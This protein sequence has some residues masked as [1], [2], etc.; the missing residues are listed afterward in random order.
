M[1]R[2]LRCS[3]LFEQVIV[4]RVIL[5]LTIGF[6]GAC[7][8]GAYA[9][10]YSGLLLCCLLSMVAG[11]VFLL[12]RSK[13]GKIGFLIFLGAV[14][15]FFWMR[16][17]DDLY[18]SDLR[19]FDGQIYQGQVTVSDYSYET[20]YGIS[21]NGKIQLEGKTYKIRIYVQDY[22]SLKPG[23]VLTG[24]MELHATTAQGAA[25]SDYH[26][27][28]GLFLVA[29]VSEDADLAV[30]DRL[31]PQYFP[32]ALKKRIVDTISLCFPE[33]TLAFARALLVGDTYLLSYEE[34]TAYQVSGIRHVVAVSGLHVSILFSLV[35]MAA[36]K[37]RVLTALLGIPVLVLFAAVAGFTPSVVRACA[38]Q[39]LMILALL[40][41]RDYD[42]P[43][44]LATAILT[45]LLINPMTV[46]SVSL[47]LSSGCIIGIFL[48]A[49]PLQDW[50]YAGFLK[51]WAKG[52][53]FMP[54]VVRWCVSSLAMTL[55]AMVITTPLSAIYFGCVSVIG[56]LINML[57]LW[58]ISF[59]FY[60]IMLVCITG[61]IWQGAGSVVAWFVSWPIRMVQSVSLAAS[62]IPFAAVYTESKYIVIW[63][64]L[65][66]VLL[67]AFFLNGKKKPLH[68]LAG[69]AISLALA[70]GV[71]VAEPVLGNYLVTVID[72]GQGQ[73]VLLRCG[74]RNYIVDC[75][76]AHG[77]EAADK[78]A[79]F[80]LSQG[81]TRLDGII[82]THYD[83]DHANGVEFLMRRI[84]AQKLFL[85]D[86]PDTQTG[87]RNELT[88]AFSE[89]IAWVNESTYFGSNDW[90]INLL[91]AQPG[92]EGNESSL[93]ILFQRKNCDILI[94]GDRPS[95]G[96][97]ALL[98][99]WQIPKLELLIAGHHGADSSTGMALLEATSP[100]VVAISVGAGNPYNHPTPEL[101]KRLEWFGCK[102]LR[103]DL[104]G[105]IHFRR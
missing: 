1:K 32:V 83:A 100:E 31:E 72:V 82:L 37:R 26:Q 10:G 41:N 51:K 24:E 87:F 38:M 70:V 9:V 7:A 54:R 95:G 69:I 15:G 57:C 28:N 36:G 93:C 52:D 17:Y 62:R 30:A 102:V 61:L 25:E 56:I 80:L 4:M 76:G 43:T 65:C 50:I 34:D 89:R 92:K 97:S 47:Q 64:F 12:L 23:D 18:L 88:E 20:Y 104:Q 81:I 59:V 78:T 11:L 35:Y 67:A 22:T 68:L 74:D 49:R 13:A 63:L 85:P 101:L 79:K 21:A 75:G 27:S 55:S 98:E 45:M 105:H 5:Y 73:S 96:E 3:A 16:C 19:R 86:T 53:G 44:A 103:T 6:A 77:E 2:A 14:F 94:T 29:Y 71:S 91:A 84:P 66:Y 42:P 40:L 39:I 33:D 8:L 58:V 48:C 46:M 99:E 60:G 90:K